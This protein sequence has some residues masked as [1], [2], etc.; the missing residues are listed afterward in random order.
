MHGKVLL[1]TEKL[2]VRQQNMGN[3][4][5]EV[6]LCVKPYTVWIS[7]RMLFHAARDM[8]FMTV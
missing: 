2:Q 8:F 4:E 7:F 3:S 1:P 5:G 6:E